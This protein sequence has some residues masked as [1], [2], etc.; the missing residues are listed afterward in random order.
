MTAVMILTNGT[1][2]T[3]RT[4]TRTAAIEAI[5]EA[6][7]LGNVKEASVYNSCDFEVVWTNGIE[8]QECWV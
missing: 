7:L 3:V 4:T 8:W 2:K 5:K 1:E 6:F